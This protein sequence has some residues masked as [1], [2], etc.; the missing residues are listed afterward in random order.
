MKCKCPP[1]GTFLGYL[2]SIEAEKLG[3]GG[4][5]I[6]EGLLIERNRPSKLASA[7]I[8]GSA[9]IGDN[10]VVKSWSTTA[11]ENCVWQ[12]ILKCCVWRLILKHCAWRVISKQCAWRHPDAIFR[13]QVSGGKFWNV[14]YYAWFWNIG[15]DVWFQNVSVASQTPARRNVLKSGSWKQ[16]S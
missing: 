1:T 10:T 2:G 16:A 15:P 6:G 14:A 12:K 3:G 7:S 9:F 4:A 13:N 5:S 11:S 8:W